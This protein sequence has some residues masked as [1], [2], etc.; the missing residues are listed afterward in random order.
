MIEAIVI[1]A[2]LI[3]GLEDCSLW[4]YDEPMERTPENIEVLR[5][6]CES[7]VAQMLEQG[8]TVTCEEYVE[9]AE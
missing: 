8:F 4:T 5:E 1:C 3:G 6:E 9:E 2:Q 7:I